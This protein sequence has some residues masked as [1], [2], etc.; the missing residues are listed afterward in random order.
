MNMYSGRVGKYITVFETKNG[1]TGVRFSI[2]VGTPQDEGFWQECILYGLLANEIS[3]ELK[4]GM[5]VSV[6]GRKKKLTYTTKSG[7]LITDD[8][9]LCNNVYILE[10]PKEYKE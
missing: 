1:H 6:V 2:Y 5:W 8:C 9:T 4:A 10:K 3:I 7:S